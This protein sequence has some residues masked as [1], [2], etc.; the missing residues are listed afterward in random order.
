MQP[1]YTFCELHPFI[2]AD[3]LL[4]AVGFSFLFVVVRAKLIIRTQ[5]CFFTVSYVNVEARGEARNGHKSWFC[6]KD[7]PL[8]T[9]P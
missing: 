7:A 6:P 4:S 2:K 9:P 1:A 8:T 5:W 3:D